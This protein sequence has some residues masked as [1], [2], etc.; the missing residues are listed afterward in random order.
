MPQQT[1][2]F[3]VFVSSTFNDMRTERG[4]L[5]EKVFP[6][7]EQFCRENGARF[8]AIDLRW[9]V[10]EESQRNQKT[11]EI[12]LNEIRRCQKLSPRPNFLI[13]LGDRYGWQPVPAVIPQTEMDA[14][15]PHLQSDSRKLV[16]DWYRL[17]ENAVPAEFVLQPWG[18]RIKEYGEWE[19]IENKLRI[20]LREAVQ[21]ANFP[22]EVL[23]KY[24][25][26][27]THQEILTGALNPPPDVADT[28]SHVLAFSRSIHNLPNDNQIKE[29]LDMEKGKPI[30]TARHN[31]R[32]FAEI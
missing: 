5:R 21:K 17:D 6:V 9:G 12:C 22:K 32:N 3:R 1:R 15:R 10:N 14:I 13:L 24:T 20:V 7:L 19:P 23:V 30:L 27:A 8:Q 29:F 11:M 16:D 28:E 31:S 4:L 2:I 18:E 25:T 26:S